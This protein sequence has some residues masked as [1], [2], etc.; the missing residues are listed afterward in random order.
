MRVS[1]DPPSTARREHERPASPER[2]RSR[3][4]HPGRSRQTRHRDRIDP[5]AS[6]N[7]PSS[8]GRGVR[9]SST[10]A[11]L[12]SRGTAAPESRPGE[13]GALPRGGFSAGRMPVAEV[14]DLSGLN[15]GIDDTTS[16][17]RSDTSRGGPFVE[18]SDP[19]PCVTHAFEPRRCPPRRASSSMNHDRR[20]SSSVS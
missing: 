5:R 17:T 16:R 7:S 19:T 4:R 2:R 9:P 1:A 8:S 11:R 15:I 14:T 10:Q 13:R 20:L 6:T 3:K 12:A 18:I